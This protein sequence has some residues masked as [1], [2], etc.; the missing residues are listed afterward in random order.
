MSEPWRTE[1]EPRDEELPLY[2]RFPDPLNLLVGL[3]SVF[4]AA[5]VL[6]GGSWWLPHVDPRWAIAGVAL[7]VGLLLLGAS[8]RPR[9][10]R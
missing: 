1:T 7:F 5:F 2:R 8:M 9:R 6:T 10:R 4:V 3:A